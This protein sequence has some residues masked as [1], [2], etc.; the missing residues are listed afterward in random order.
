MVEDQLERIDRLVRKLD[1]E[2]A[3]AAEPIRS[4]KHEAAYLR[5]ALGGLEPISSRKSRWQMLKE[6]LFSEHVGG[7]QV[8]WFAAALAMAVFAVVVAPTIL[9]P[10]AEPVPVYSLIIAGDAKVMDSAAPSQGLVDVDSLLT[11]TLRPETTVR[12]KVEVRVFRIEGNKA[13]IWNVELPRASSGLFSLSATPR[14]LAMEVGAWDLLF[15]IGLPADLPTEEQVGRTLE[16]HTS[17]SK[18]KWQS[19]RQRVEVVAHQ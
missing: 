8:R 17:S 2:S 10:S 7:G 19:L 4:P 5:L 14:Q 16:S 13:Q 18:Q 12:A 15:A 11:I 9:H 3:A 1:D 6:R